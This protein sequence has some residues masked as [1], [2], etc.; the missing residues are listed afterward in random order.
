MSHLS[1]SIAMCTYNGSV[2]LTAQLGSIASQ[3]QLPDEL[4]IC[5]DGSTD[6]TLSVLNSFA[7]QAS[8]PVRVFP[9]KKRLGPAKNFEKTIGLCTGDVIVLCD[10]DDLWHPQKLEKLREVFERH[11]NAVYA[12]SD[13]EMVDQEGV[14]LGENLWEAI[15]FRQRLDEF[16][17]PGQLKLLLK[18]NLITGAAMAFRAS[19]RDIVLPIPSG[20]MHD[21]WI[22]LLGSA[23]ACGVPIP[24]ALFQYRRHATQVVG[25][26]KQ[27]FLQVCKTSLAAGQEDWW[28]KV[29]DFRKLQERVT[30][31]P[32]TRCP[33]ECIRLLKQK[34]IHL[35][36][37]ART[38]ASTGI[39]RIAKVLAEAVTGR[40]QRYSDSWYSIVRDLKIV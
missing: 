30:S 4:I 15:A 17:G 11:P 37:R 31:D 14:S 32:F 38:R 1:I 18:Q 23:L 29:E 26:R 20:W 9:N 25:W 39:P 6:D 3:S 7:S 16:S 10:Q 27:T 40:Y 35:L 28:Q 22:V 2:F 12:F 19:F 24:E 36:T 13:A 8:F 5:D 34:E 21:Y 33:Q